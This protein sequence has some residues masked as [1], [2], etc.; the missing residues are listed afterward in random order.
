MLGFRYICTRCGT[1]APPNH[2]NMSCPICKGV[3]RGEGAPGLIGTR[4][5]FGIKNEFIDNG[6][7]IDNWRSW[8]KAG[9]RDAVD[10][11][12]NLDVKKKIQNKVDKIQKKKVSVAV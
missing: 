12:K 3:L 4:D 5:N 10:V 1:E 7:V 8:E 2:Q 6:E 11:T 9:F